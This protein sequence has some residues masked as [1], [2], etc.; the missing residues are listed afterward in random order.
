MRLT[1]FLS[2]DRA[3]ADVIPPGPKVVYNTGR[4]FKATNSVKYPIYK[5]VTQEV[6]ANR[7]WRGMISYGV[8]SGLSDAAPLSSVRGL[9]NTS[10]FGTFVTVQ[11]AGEVEVLAPRP[12]GSS[13]GLVHGCYLTPMLRQAAPDGSEPVFGVYLGEPRKSGNPR[14]QAA[15][16]LLTPVA[17]IA[18]HP[19]PQ[20]GSGAL[21][22]GAAAESV[23]EDDL[24]EAE[25]QHWL[26]TSELLPRL[27]L[28]AEEYARDEIIAELKEKM[29]FLPWAPESA[30]RTNK[31][32]RII[33]NLM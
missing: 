31:L 18:Q 2:V 28:C 15:T 24:T 3:S 13:S 10:P 12:R 29:S 22:L 32:L 16:V 33:M 21:A 5:I 19:N 25:V 26:T 8:I 14:L 30:A 1:G 23:P 17:P 4:M 27:E 7:E 11:V 6:V 20:L 9:S